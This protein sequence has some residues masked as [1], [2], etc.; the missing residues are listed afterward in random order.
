MLLFRS[1][2]G[3]VSVHVRLRLIELT[4]SLDKPILALRSLLAALSTSPSHPSTHYQLVQ[5]R[6]KITNDKSGQF[7][8][9]PKSLESLES[10]LSKHLAKDADLTKFNDH[11]LQEHSEDAPAVRAALRLR[12]EILKPDSK[13]EVSADLIRI[14]AL[15]SSDLK[16]ATEG[17]QVLKDLKPEQKHL[18]LYLA[19]AKER[20]PEA[21]VFGAGE[22]A[23]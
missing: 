18:D 4:N 6:H 17:L 19:A 2:L 9:S 20:Y 1:T 15:D 22:K 8:S 5:L 3:V 11:Y 23:G 10:E 7:T 13:G 14:L 16:D 12:G 21:K